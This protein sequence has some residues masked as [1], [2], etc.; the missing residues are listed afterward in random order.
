[1]VDIFQ[2]KES[3]LDE[4]I[5]AVL[6]RMKDAKP[7]SD[8]YKKLLNNLDKLMELQREER[9]SGISPDAVVS[10]VASLLGILTIVAYEQKH[11]MTSKALGFV[12]R[13][14]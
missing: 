6:T 7:D 13:S 14:K 9:S 4:P 1:M 8:E 5:D 12:L 10:A 2:K 11:V 3:K